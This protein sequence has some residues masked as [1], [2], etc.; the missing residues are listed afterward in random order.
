MFQYLIS[1]YIN[2]SPYGSK[3]MRYALW[4]FVFTFFSY[5]RSSYI[6]MSLRVD[7][8]CNVYALIMLCW[9]LFKSRF[10]LYHLYP[11]TL[12]SGGYY[13]SEQS[14]MITLMKTTNIFGWFACSY[15]IHW[16]INW[17]FWPKLVEHSFSG[18]KYVKMTLM[19][20]WIEAFG[21]LTMLILLLETNVLP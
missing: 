8:A 12:I 15:T 2:Y 5:L 6:S 19:L 18:P 11:G 21:P 9:F 17:M 14:Y 7:A 4:T 1:P 20:D 13:I 10:F 3:C 16:W